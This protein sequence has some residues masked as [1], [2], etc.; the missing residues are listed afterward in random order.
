M[1]GSAAFVG[2]RDVSDLRVAPRRGSDVRV[3]GKDEDDVRAF[4]GDL[5]EG[6]VRA[7]HVGVPLDRDEPEVGDPLIESGLHDVID[8]AGGMVQQGDGRRGVSEKGKGRRP[9]T[10]QDDDCANQSQQ[11]VAAAALETADFGGARCRRLR[12]CGTTVN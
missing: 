3:Q 9:A 1:F 10:S 11:P 8:R 5:L 4:V 6:L 2:A 7:G 12:L